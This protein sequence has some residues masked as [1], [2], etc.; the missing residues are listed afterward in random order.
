MNI[1]GTWWYAAFQQIFPHLGAPVRCSGAY[2]NHCTYI[3]S[4]LYLGLQI[5]YR[6]NVYAKFKLHYS[7]HK[8]FTDAALQTLEVCSSMRTRRITLLRHWRA[9]LVTRV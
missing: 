2:F 7:I 6:Y 5:A 3:H 9:S 4:I 1:A 8:Y